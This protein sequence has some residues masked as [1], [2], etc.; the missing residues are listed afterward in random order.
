MKVSIQDPYVY[1]ESESGWLQRS[2]IKYF[3]ERFITKKKETG[4][5]S[6][7]EREVFNSLKNKYPEYII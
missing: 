1:Y 7:T 2:E 4:Y 3:M 5:T 6:M